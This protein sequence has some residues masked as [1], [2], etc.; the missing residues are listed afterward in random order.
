[1]RAGQRKVAAAFTANRSDFFDVTGS[2]RP[3]MENFKIEKTIIAPQIQQHAS[4]SLQEFILICTW[5]GRNSEESMF[6]SE[7]GASNIA[8]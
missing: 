7:N 5:C 2:R 1:M 3:L 4:R 8:K 6:L